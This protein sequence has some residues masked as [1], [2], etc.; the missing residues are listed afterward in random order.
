[1]A[2]PPFLYV[3]PSKSNLSRTKI[4]HMFLH[5]VY[6]ARTTVPTCWRTFLCYTCMTGGTAR[7]PSDTGSTLSCK[8]NGICM[9]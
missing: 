8:W 5:V 1:M 4:F 3:N 6:E 2:R 7:V 9:L